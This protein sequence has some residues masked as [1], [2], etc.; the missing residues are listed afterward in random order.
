MRLFS[1]YR[2][3]TLKALRTQGFRGPAAS[4]ARTCNHDVFDL[5]RQCSVLVRFRSLARLPRPTLFF[6]CKHNKNSPTCL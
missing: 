4:L 5:S 3:R 6:D 2:D 1:E